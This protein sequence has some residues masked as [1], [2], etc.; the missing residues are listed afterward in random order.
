MATLPNVS[1]QEP[2]TAA[3]ANSVIA[4]GNA[5]EPTAWTNVTFNSPWANYGAGFSNAQYRKVGEM[6]QVRGLVKATGITVPSLIF[7]LPV[8]F[9]PPA[10]L[11]FAT[12]GGGNHA[13]LQMGADGQLSLL[14]PSGAAAA[15]NINYAFS[16][17]A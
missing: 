13:L 4:Q 10:N 2:I 15:L 11:Q 14:Q 7:I 12:D 17:T 8:G 16:I 1:S 5:Q 3:W 6:V 9:R